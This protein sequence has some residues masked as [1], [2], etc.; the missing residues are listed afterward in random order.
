M[1][2]SRR[3]T[4]IIGMT[5]DRSEKKDKRIA[6]RKMRARTRDLL[7]LADEDT[8]FPDNLSEVA[9]PYDGVKDG[10]HY[11]FRKPLDPE[12]TEGYVKG[13]KPDHYDKLMRK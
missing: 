11:F 3:Q 7:R 8:I 4:P 2:R 10:K 12:E 13:T 9:N 6:N 5:G 1:S